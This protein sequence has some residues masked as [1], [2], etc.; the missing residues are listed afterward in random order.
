MA[1]PLA[2][3][4]S[5]FISWLDKLL[6]TAW[7]KSVC[8]GIAVLVVI[9]LVLLL[10]G[11]VF[12]FSPPIEG[13]AA[14]HAVYEFSGTGYEEGSEEGGVQPNRFDLGESLYYLSSKWRIDLTADADPSCVQAS[15]PAPCD[16]STVVVS[17]R[18]L[19]T[20]EVLIDGLFLEGFNQL[21]R[22]W[23]FET[24]LQDLYEL[25]VSASGVDSWV[26]AVE[27]WQ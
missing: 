19:D 18:N 20:G 11:N 22:M 15:A 13:D 2:V 26:V 16:S 17:L 8:A 21:S 27:Q 5:R 24:G 12:F 25:T 6:D 23:E 10:M 1:N 14:W 7:K 9:L 3:F 4:W